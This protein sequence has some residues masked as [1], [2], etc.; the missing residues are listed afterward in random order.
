M[1]DVKT[2]MP[3][4]EQVVRMNLDSVEHSKLDPRSHM[5]V[6]IAALAATGAAPIAWTANLGAAAEVGVTVEEIQGVLVAITPLIG[7]ARSVSAAGAALR[8][9]GLASLAAEAGAEDD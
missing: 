8:G 7:T 2:E 3:V 4:L 1:S 5:M 6:R 9:L